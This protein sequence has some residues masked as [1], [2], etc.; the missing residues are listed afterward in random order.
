MGHSSNRVSELVKRAFDVGVSLIAII[1]L[2][3][4]VL[5]LVAIIKIS[6]P[7]PTFYRG[8]RIGLH[9]VPFRIFKLRTMVVNAEELGGSATAQDDPRIT[10]IG[11]FIRRHK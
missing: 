3:P 7:G 6:S 11:H 5:V 8:I 10:P 1:L 2:S 4:V 9:G